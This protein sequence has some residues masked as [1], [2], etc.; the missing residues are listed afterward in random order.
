MARTPKEERVKKGNAAE[1]LFNDPILSEAFEKLEAKYNSAWV[2]SGLEDNQKRET[3]YLSIRALGELRLELES[4][5]NTGKI[6]Q[7]EQ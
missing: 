1:K 6:A 5:I 2:S 7:Q 3:L 4:M